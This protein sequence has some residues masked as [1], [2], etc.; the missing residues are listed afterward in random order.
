MISVAILWSSRTQVIGHEFLIK[1]IRTQPGS[2][3]RYAHN[4]LEHFGTA[5]TRSPWYPFSTPANSGGDEI[6]TFVNNIV[7]FPG[8]VNPTLPQSAGSPGNAN[9]NAFVGPNSEPS[10]QG[11]AGV[12]AGTQK[13]DLD[14]NADFTLQASSPARNIGVGL[15]SGFEDPL[16][17]QN[18]DDAGPF[19]FNFSPGADWPRPAVLA[20]DL[21][22][23]PPRWTSPGNGGA[24]SNPNPVLFPNVEFGGAFAPW[25]IPASEIATHPQNNRIL[26]ELYNACPGLLNINVNRFSQV[27]Y[28]GADADTTIRIVRTSTRFGGN[29]NTGDRVPWNF[30]Q[31]TT[32]GNFDS[33]D[34]DSYTIIIMP[35]G[36]Y[37]EFFKSLVVNGQLECGRATLLKTGVDNNG[38]DA[39]V[40]IKQ[41]VNRNSRACGIHHVIGP[42]LR[43]DITNGRIDHALTWTYPNPTQFL[44]V[45]PAIKGAGGTGGPAGRGGMGYRVVWDGLTDNEI[46][47]WLQN[48][49]PSQSRAVMEIVANCL[50]EFGVI[51][52]DHSGSQSN[53]RGSLSFEH[54]LTG[55][56]SQVGVTQNDV[57]FVLHDL[58]GPAQTVHAFS[59]SLRTSAIMTAMFAV[60]L[61]SRTR[62]AIHAPDRHDRTAHRASIIVGGLHA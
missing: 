28:D 22:S 33:S 51:T 15:P 53:R 44:H 62:P 26:N 1:T 8:N 61:A 9:G 30:S 48:D 39:N 16:G 17:G 38:P 2:N 25:A 31:F 55:F 3:V 40:F 45:P 21:D 29:L 41:N 27:Y 42:V 59:P 34:I 7:V 10:I 19:P 37:Y 50:R 14:L 36:T 32:P 4:Y 20:F 58:L 54:D 24:G 52:T 23:T 43:R 13:A 5:G 49:V 12:F 11:G 57:R 47:T 35:D 46:D 18:N 56:W 6:D 60:I